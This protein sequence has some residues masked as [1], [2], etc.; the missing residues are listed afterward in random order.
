MLTRYRGVLLLSDGE[1]VTAECKRC[2]EPA[3]FAGQYALVESSCW[4]WQHSEAHEAGMA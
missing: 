4:A 2:G 3:L 1:A